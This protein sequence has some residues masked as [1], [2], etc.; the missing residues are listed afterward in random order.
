MGTI[1]A[2]SP[3]LNSHWFS[4]QHSILANM[5][6]S[7]GHGMPPTGSYPPKSRSK[8]DV[9]SSFIEKLQSRRNLDLTP[10][11]L[12]GIEQHFRLL[13]S[14]Y[15]LDVNIGSL[16]VLNHKRL[17]DSA[18]ADPSAVS[19]QVRPVDIVSGV[20]KAAM[21]R[22]PSFGNAESLLEVSEVKRN[23]SNSKLNEHT[24]MENIFIGQRSVAK[25]SMD[26]SSQSTR[27]AENSFIKQI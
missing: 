21:D 13:P 11:L 22:R 23:Y 7:F 24:K 16:D 19:F 18:R 20:G 10:T 14:R 26:L 8:M 15:A 12:E 9:C 1:L 5:S 6:G 3:E 27:R 2:S 17:L 25:V 4:Q